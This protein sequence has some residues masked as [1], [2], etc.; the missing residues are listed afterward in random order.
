[1]VTAG[2][3]LK[4]KRESLGK[5]ISQISQETKIQERFLEYIENDEY[6]RFDSDVFVNGFIKIYSDNLGLDTERVLALYRR[7]N[8]HVFENKQ[9][10]ISK[11][12]DLKKKILSPKNISIALILIFLISILSYIGYEIYLFQNPPV[13]E[14][15]MPE[16][17]F[18]TSENTITIEGNTSNTTYVKIADK[19]IDLNNNGTFS[20]EYTLEEGENSIT[21]KALKEQTK[22]ETSAT[23]T[24]T[25]EPVEVIDNN[26]EEKDDEYVL[27]LVIINAETWIKLDIDGVNKISQTVEPSE[28]EYTV[29]DRFEIISGRPANTKIYVNDE[30]YELVQD[31]SSGTYSL[32]CEVLQSGLLCE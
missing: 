28:F 25:Y 14:I 22:Q 8:G 18:V 5:T 6:E 11:K 13:L 31:P 26:E 7:G 27:R 19:E 10:T 29:E 16:D 20:F 32:S 4:T 9:K 1:M 30:A 24:I 17:N 3:V 2:E 15:T 12:K 23:V 21:L